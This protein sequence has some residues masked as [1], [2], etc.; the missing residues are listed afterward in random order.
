MTK[1]SESAVKEQ[2][3]QLAGWQ[4]SGNTITKKFTL[5]SFKEAITFVNRVADLAE[6]ADHHPDFTINYRN[7]TLTLSTHS[8]GG[9]T[10][11]DIRLAKQIEAV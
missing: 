6:A 2:L 11:N 9:I 1:L 10:E 8:E 3:E 7:V 4:L 5:P